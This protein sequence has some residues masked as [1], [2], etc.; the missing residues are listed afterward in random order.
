VPYQ[1]IGT[2]LRAH[3]DAGIDTALVELP[4]PSMTLPTDS[5]A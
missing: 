3:M 2:Q 4:A 1:D 5:F